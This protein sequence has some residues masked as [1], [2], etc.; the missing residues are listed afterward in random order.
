MSVPLSKINFVAKKINS[1][2]II[3]GTAKTINDI[4]EKYIGPSKKYTGP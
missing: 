2:K 1:S 4:K 3:Y